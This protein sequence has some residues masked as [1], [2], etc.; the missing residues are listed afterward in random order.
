MEVDVKN[1]RNM[2][3]QPP[4][5]LLN[6]LQKATKTPWLGQQIHVQKPPQSPAAPADG[7]SSEPK[8]M[9]LK[10]KLKIANSRS[11]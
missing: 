10:K 11:A 1:S 3:G 7:A 6:F 2:A 5:D 9:F 4:S 8:G